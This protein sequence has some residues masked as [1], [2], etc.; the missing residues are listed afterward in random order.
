MALIFYLLVLLVSFYL[1]A[2]ICDRYFVESL[3][4]IA[5]R[6]GLSSD[7]AGAT[8]MAMGSSAPELFVALI[9]VFR[10]GHEQIGTGTIV[11][12]AL[13][14][15]LAIIGAVAV[16]KQAKVAWQPV[17]RDL[18]FYSVAILLLFWAFY[19]SQI[20]LVE[21]GVFIVAYIV[22]VF[23][24]SRWRKWFHYQDKE[25]VEEYP[26]TEASAPAEGRVQKLT[27]PLDWLL[28]RFFP[29]AQHYFWIFLISIVLISGLSWVLVESAIHISLILS[30]IHI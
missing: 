23:S 3:D 2:Q 8:L 10:P 27:R 9:A 21:A 20:S 19:D 13:F 15:V 17:V 7:V 6:F 28:A 29:S 30:L 25:P 18:L 14:N 1:L 24:V 5:T 22:Y 16:V 12:S 4:R 11:G 26:E